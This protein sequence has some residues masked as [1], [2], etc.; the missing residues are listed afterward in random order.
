MIDIGVQMRQ[1]L[2]EGLGAPVPR[3]MPGGGSSSSQTS[4]SVS[5]D[6]SGAVLNNGMDMAVFQAMVLQTVRKGMRGY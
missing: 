1:G 5:N 4:V 6:F 2:L 3:L